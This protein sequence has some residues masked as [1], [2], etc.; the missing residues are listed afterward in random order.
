[1][2]RVLGVGD[3]EFG[4]PYWDWAGD[5]SDFDAQRQR[6]DLPLWQV[7]GGNGVGAFRELQ[8]GPFATGAGFRVNVEQAPNG[9]IRATDRPLRRNFGEARDQFGRL[10]AQSMFRFDEHDVVL[11]LVVVEELDRQKTRMDEVGAN[12]RRAI[13]LLEELGASEAGGLA[14]Q[15][16]LPAGGTLRIEL[17]GIHSARLPEVLDPATPDHR[18]LATCLNLDDHTPRF[19]RVVKILASLLRIAD[20][21]DRTHFSLVRA[22]NVKF[23]KQIMIEIHLAGDA[24]MELWA[25]KS[26]ADLFEQVFHRRIQFSK[27]LLETR[28]S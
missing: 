10:V 9:Q 21:L 8:D 3:D 5:G 16:P 18:I 4:M 25:A 17:N 22:V 11:P 28:K 14:D 15:H 24:E 7:V 6:T 20:G 1:M 26:R 2:R 12:A 13:R 19:Q 27:V 23:G